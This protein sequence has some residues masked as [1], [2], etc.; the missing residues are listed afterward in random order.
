M[1]VRSYAPSIRS[2]RR[3]ACRLKLSLCGS[4]WLPLAL[5]LAPLDRTPKRAEYF[6]TVEITLTPELN[7][8][9]EEK[10]ASG[11]YEN[12]S[13]VVREALR[14]LFEREPVLEWLRREAR[15]GFTQLENG[16]TVELTREQFISQMHDRHAR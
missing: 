16:H 1:G 5:A 4:L 11:L 10:V 2:V 14:L 12:P 9:V 15:L 6:E 3:C 7:R 13:E 8:L